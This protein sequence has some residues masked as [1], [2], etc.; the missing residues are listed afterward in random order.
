MKIAKS[1][2]RIRPGFFVGLF[3]VFVILPVLF[4]G[5]GGGKPTTRDLTRFRCS[6]FLSYAKSVSTNDEFKADFSK[7]QESGKWRTGVARHV[8]SPF[9]NKPQLEAARTYQEL[10]DSPRAIFNTNQN[11]WVKINLTL[12]ASN[13]EP[14][15]VC[16][17]QFYFRRPANSFGCK[18]GW[19]KPAFAVGYSDET[20][21]L[22]SQEDFNSLDLS[23]FVPLSSLGVEG[24]HVLFTNEELPKP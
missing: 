9:T 23:G 17:Q 11:F 4:P 7:L 8:S 24:F 5:Y 16:K 12:H 1:E 2:L 3:A 20:T 14:V 22:V 10:Y 19:L 13:R 21:G 15:I 18:Y 6:D